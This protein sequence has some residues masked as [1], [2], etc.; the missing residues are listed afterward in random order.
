MEFDGTR[1]TRVCSIASAFSDDSP[2]RGFSPTTRSR[3]MT[4][5]ALTDQTARRDFSRL[6][7][8]RSLHRTAGFPSRSICRPGRFSGLQQ[9]VATTK[10]K[11]P[12]SRRP[13]DRHHGRRISSIPVWQD[14][15]RAISLRRTARDTRSARAISRSQDAMDSEPWRPPQNDSGLTARFAAFGTD[16]D[17]PGHNDTD[18]SS[19]AASPPAQ[20]E[21]SSPMRSI[22]R[23]IILRGEMGYQLDRAPRSTSPTNKAFG[24]KTRRTAR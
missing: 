16:F 5:T 7:R 12:Y 18:D 15:E 20:A 11:T 24:E 3:A 13:D 21:A 10:R 1:A 9:S 17:E 2:G 6:S 14:G 8:R 22:P 23:S 19:R 4:I